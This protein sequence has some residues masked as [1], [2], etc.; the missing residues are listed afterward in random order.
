M[1]Q[2]IHDI[3]ASRF[4]NTETE[5]KNKS[6]ILLVLHTDVERKSEPG[7]T[8]R[9]SL[10]PCGRIPRGENNAGFFFERFAGYNQ[11]W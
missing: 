6:S 3:W 2:Q 5:I 7:P 1:L 10:T 9:R 8:Q 4:T 11:I